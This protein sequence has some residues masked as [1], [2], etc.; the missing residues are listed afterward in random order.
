MNIL[1]TGGTGFIGSYFVPLLLEQGHKV[2]LLVR[3]EKRA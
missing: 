2:R 3:D 1:V